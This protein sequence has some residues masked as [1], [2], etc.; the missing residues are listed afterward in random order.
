MLFVLNPRSGPP[1]TGSFIDL[2]RSQEKQTLRL[3]DKEIKKNWME[4]GFPGQIYSP[5]SPDP[6]LRSSFALEAAAGSQLGHPLAAAHPAAL[7]QTP[8]NCPDPPIGQEPLRSLVPELSRCFQA[9]QSLEV[10]EM[11]AIKPRYPI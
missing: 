7:A 5:G 2:L 6:F 8:K 1:V 9:R 11:K 10:E 4:M 3:A